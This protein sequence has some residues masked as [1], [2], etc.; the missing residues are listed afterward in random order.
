MKKAKKKKIIQGNAEP[1]VMDEKTLELHRKLWGIKLPSPIKLKKPRTREETFKLLKEGKLRLKGKANRLV[2]SEYE[3]EATEDAEKREKSKYI[4]DNFHKRKQPIKKRKIRKEYI[5]IKGHNSKGKEEFWKVRLVKKPKLKEEPHKTPFI[6]ESTFGN[7]RQRQVEVTDLIRRLWDKRNQVD[8]W[9]PGVYDRMPDDL[10]LLFDENVRNENGKKRRLTSFEFLEIEPDMI[11]KMIKPLRS[12]ILSRLKKFENERNERRRSKPML[13]EEKQRYV[14]KLKADEAKTKYLS[15]IASYL[16]DNLYNGIREM[17]DEEGKKYQHRMKEFQRTVDTASNMI[18]KDMDRFIETT[19]KNEIED[20][21]SLRREALEEEIMTTAVHKEKEL[22][23]SYKNIFLPS[24]LS[25]QKELFQLEMS[26][27]IQYWTTK[28]REIEKEVGIQKQYLNKQL[29]TIKILQAAE[30]IPSLK[31]SFCDKV[32]KVH[33]EGKQKIEEALIPL[34]DKIE[35]Y[36]NLQIKNNQLLDSIKNHATVLSELIRKLKEFVNITQPRCNERDKFMK[37]LEKLE[38]FKQKLL[39]HKIVETPDT[40][41][42]SVEYLTK[43]ESDISVVEPVQPVKEEE[44]EMFISMAD[45]ILS[46]GDLDESAKYLLKIKFII[47]DLLKRII[48]SGTMTEEEDSI[49]DIR[50]FKHVE[51]DL[52]SEEETL[53]IVGDKYSI[54]DLVRIGSYLNKRRA[55]IERILEK[56]REMLEKI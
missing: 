51:G 31:N 34:K 48:P 9:L 55:S 46:D 23:Y 36:V 53:I 16:K 5:F 10:L 15:R 45:R 26:S 33:K 37:D 27:Y 40:S 35:I 39:D 19:I 43:T 11:A 18:M 54:P 50:S 22:E 17:I 44:E 41:S 4:K 25:K 13:E 29:E 8:P 24:E 2:V 32:K 47:S 52:M 30:H 21:L 12:P 56:H 3:T 42:T 20:A 49:E 1:V 7:E 14:R 28:T 6:Y 38:Q